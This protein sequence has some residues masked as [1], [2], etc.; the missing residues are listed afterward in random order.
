MT[1]NT[2]SYQHIEYVTALKSFTM[3]VSLNHFFYPNYE[4]PTYAL[5]ESARV[6]MKPLHLAESQLVE[7]H[8]AEIRRNYFKYYLTRP[9]KYS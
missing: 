3:Q 9:N 4:V 5:V 1:T 2:L 6:L 7:R 8:L